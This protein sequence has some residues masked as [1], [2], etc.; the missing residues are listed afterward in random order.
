MHSLAIRPVT[1][2]CFN[3]LI[4][5]LASSSDDT[6]LSTISFPACPMY[7][8]LSHFLVGKAI[9]SKVLVVSTKCLNPHCK[10]KSFPLSV[11]RIREYQRPTDRVAKEGVTSNISDN[12]PVDR[13]ISIYPLS[14]RFFLSKQKRE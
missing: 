1:P 2:T 12:I 7:D 3:L 9:L 10:V 14:R 8:I 6:T 13:I 4:R 11:K 5:F